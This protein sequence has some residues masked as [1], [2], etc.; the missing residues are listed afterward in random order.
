MRL[1]LRNLLAYLDGILEPEDAQDI[2]QKIKD[3]KYAA[4]LMHRIRDLTRRMRLAAPSASDRGPGLDPNTVAEY[5]DNMLSP[6]RVVDF[7]KVCLESDIHLAEV[8]ACHQI[9]SLVLGE[10]MEIEPAARQ[11]MYQIG[12]SAAGR[13][14]AA[15][16]PPPIPPAPP[17][18]PGAERRQP[19]VRPAVPDYLR[20]PRKKHRWLTRLG[21]GAGVIC[22]A[23]VLLPVFGQFEPGTPIGDLLVRWNLVE[24]PRQA[25][26][27]PAQAIPPKADA[28]PDETQAAVPGPAVPP[29]AAAP[30]TLPDEPSPP[31]GPSPEKAPPAETPDVKLPGGPPPEKAESPPAAGETPP[32]EEVPESPPGP[33]AIPTE[34]SPLPQPETPPQVPAPESAGGTS[35]PPIGPTGE[36]GPAAPAPPPVPTF[37]P[38]V[39]APGTATTEPAPAAV[40]PNPPETKTAPPVAPASEGMGRLMS[41][42]QILLSTMEET[43]DWQR[44]AP[45]EILGP[46]QPFLALLT[47]RPVLALSTGVTLQLLGGTQVELLPGKDSEPPGLE[48]RFGRVVLMP[49]A[50]PGVKLRLVLPNRSGTLTF[51][52]ADAEVA[53]EVRRVV[54]P[55]ANPEGKEAWYVADLY[56]PAGQVKW[57]E[58]GQKPLDGSAPDHFVLLDNRAAS[59]TQDVGEPP[60]WVTAEAIG[61]LEHGASQALL[62]GVALK[63]PVRQSLLELSEHRKREVRW[64]ATRCL[65]YLGYFDPMVSALGDLNAK[66]DWKDIIGQLRE[67]VLRDATA[68]AAV[69]R[70][71]EKHY[72][73]LA[74]D[75][76]RML[77]GYTDRDLAAGEDARLVEWLDHDNLAVR[78][79]S[80]WNLRELTGG[81]GLYYRPE[82]NINRRR[83]P[84][85]AWK[86]R[87]EAGEI[88]LQASEEKTGPPAKENVPAPAGE[89][90]L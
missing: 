84:V 25:A 13:D 23:L 19:R 68:A 56:V 1:T 74:P 5:L 83:Q 66:P 71:L 18:R 50:N 42:D 65:G 75:L 70:T 73:P 64:L 47:Y 44:V 10:P 76:Y 6:D 8:A 60:K 30:V 34:E 4:D 81:K 16:V 31:A 48:V 12:Q 3:S 55:G 90:E 29:S 37:P 26:A 51:L 85:Q 38:P 86:Q 87:L 9:L 15:S 35:P 58:P 72:G 52:S 7:E 14:A 41:D 61:V 40:A 2:A 20:E 54:P 89:R 78:V 11:R 57:E 33:T 21:V 77:W 17:P 46:R 80:F 27:I 63:V 36:T 88:R 53:V 39:E 49:L 24:Q 28:V 79:L 45:R 43:T 82:Y 32:K 69:R 67:S 59:K 62:Q 22:V